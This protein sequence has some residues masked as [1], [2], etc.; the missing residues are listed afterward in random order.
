MA[1]LNEPKD[2]TTGDVAKLLGISQQTVIKCF[3]S[4]I[5]KGYRVPG[6]KFRRIPAKH[7]IRFMNKGFE[8]YYPEDKKRQVWAAL[9]A[10]GLLEDLNQVTWNQFKTDDMLGEISDAL[11]AK[12]VEKRILE[13][14]Q[15][16][17]VANDK[18]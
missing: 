3:E 12:L 1:R 2:L 7:L 16:D 5:L 13:T 6:S 4:G 18:Q 14:S 9:E 17:S 15:S 8:G 11:R 10:R